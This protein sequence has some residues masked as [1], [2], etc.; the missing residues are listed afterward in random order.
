MQKVPLEEE[1]ENPRSTDLSPVALQ[2]LEYLSVHPEAQDTVEGIAEWWL[3]E[4]RIRNV[5][6]EVKMTLAELVV[7]GWLLQ[8][9]GLDGRVHYLVNPS[10]HRVPVGNLSDAPQTSA[11]A[12]PCSTGGST[13]TQTNRK[14]GK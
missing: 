14:P 6:A 11:L 7:H 5:I 8:R 13:L 3:L 10:R 9:S 4:Q 1:T 2:I 12:E